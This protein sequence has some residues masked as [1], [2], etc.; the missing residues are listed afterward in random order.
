MHITILGA[1][2]YG[3]ALAKIL[4]QNFHTVQFFDPL[5]YRIDLNSALKNTAAIILATPSEILPDIIQTLP[6]HL[7][8]ICTS[9]GLLHPALIK[10]FQDFSV[11]A[12]PAF[13]NDLN[14]QKPT[15]LTITSS[16]AGKL[17]TRPFLTF[18][19]TED[20]HGVLLCGTLKNI[21]AVQAGIRH[22]EPGTR[23][24]LE[25][26]TKAHQET[27]TALKHSQLNPA[28][29]LLSCGIDDLILT[30]SSI[31]SRNY[32]L[33]QNITLGTANQ[34]IQDIPTIESLY[35]V[36][37]YYHILENIPNTPILHAT[38]KE[39]LSV[40]NSSKTTPSSFNYSTL[41]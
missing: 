26:I 10:D 4:S 16:L 8:V 34:F 21:Y 12:G 18:Q 22:L 17:L 39:I 9:K 28:T 2:A 35:S 20:L 7:P 19:F 37:L 27:I 15:T 33:G 6:K 41:H 36:K 13:A 38:I 14:Q 25:F 32:R 31:K 29:A 23:H 24:F 5:K 40:L 3:T 1:G 30:S 11:L